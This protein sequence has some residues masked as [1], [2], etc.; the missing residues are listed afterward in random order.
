[1]A[2]NTD[3]FVEP[4][5]LEERESITITV[6]LDPAHRRMD[7]AL[8]EGDLDVEAIVSQ[9]VSPDVE[10]TL[11]DVMQTMKYEQEQ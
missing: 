2:N 9:N 7:L 11:Y 3:S 5:D 6:P 8:R 10:Q 1:M 4:D